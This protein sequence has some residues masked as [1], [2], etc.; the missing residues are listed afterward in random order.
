MRT[1]NRIDVLI[2]GVLTIFLLNMVAVYVGENEGIF[3]TVC[4][5]IVTLVGYAFIRPVVVKQCDINGGI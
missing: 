2:F 4:G 1:V 3:V 5:A